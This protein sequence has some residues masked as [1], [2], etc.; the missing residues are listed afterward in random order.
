MGLFTDGDGIPLAFSTFPG[1]QNEQKSLEPLEQKVIGEFGCEKFI[2]CSDSGLGSENNRLLNHTGN[3]AYIVTQSIKKLAAEYREAALNRKGFQRLSDNR[4]VDL[5]QLDEKDYEELFYKEEPYSTKKLENRLLITYS[6]KYAAY[7]KEIRT[8]Q[9]DRALHM[10]KDGNHKKTSKN[11]ND[12]ARFIDKAAVTKDGEKADILYFLDESKIA[13]EERYDGL[14]AV[15]TDLFDDNPADLLKVS[16]GRWQ[17]EAC[18]RIMKTDFEARPVYVRREDCIEAHFLICFLSL[19]VYRLLEKKL[20]GTY[21][22]CEI[23][24]TL[25]SF[26]FADVQGQGFMPVYEVTELTD[27]LHE[28]LGFATDYE[29]LTKSRMKTIEKLSKQR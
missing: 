28:L 21:T 16:E 6:P 19:L 12:P 1:N 26:K 13:E 24:D 17:I 7:Q 29:F 18:F 5:D 11:P 2:F 3:R 14:Y 15:C 9:V 27:R 20:G 23:L 10:L 4:L 22:C 25:R 8:K